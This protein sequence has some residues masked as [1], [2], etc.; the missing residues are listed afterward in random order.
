MY[1]GL[2]REIPCCR[3]P[4]QCRSNRVTVYQVLYDLKPT[5]FYPK[6]LHLL[7]PISR[8]FLKLLLPPQLSQALGNGQRLCDNIWT[9]YYPRTEWWWSKGWRLVYMMWKDLLNLWKLLKQIICAS[10]SWKAGR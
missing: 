4:N 5:N 6:L 3:L 9:F 1:I 8:P 7:D 10:N 2:K